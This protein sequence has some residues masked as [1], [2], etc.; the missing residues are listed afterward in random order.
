MRKLRY[1]SVHGHCETPCP[2][3][4]GKDKNGFSGGNPEYFHGVMVGSASCSGNHFYGTK[5]CK[6]FQGDVG[7][8]TILCSHE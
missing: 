7:I 1:V 2:V 8:D 4:L 5:P 6:H 3:E